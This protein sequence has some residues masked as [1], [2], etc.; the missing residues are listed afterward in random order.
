VEPTEEVAEAA[1]EDMVDVDVDMLDEEQVLEEA[2]VEGEAEEVEVIGAMETGS[3]MPCARRSENWY[4][5][6]WLCC[7]L[8]P[9][10][11][12]CSGR[13]ACCYR[14]GRERVQES[15]RE[16]KRVQ[17]SSRERVQEFKSS[18]ER[19]ERRACSSRAVSDDR[20]SVCIWA[21]LRSLLSAL[22]LSVGD[23][24]SR[25]THVLVHLPLGNGEEAPRA[26]L[27]Q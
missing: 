17:E 24:K 9:F 4:A 19:R 5:I 8:L 20:E 12:V 22:S 21:S 6:S 7:M 26:R 23:R 25:S 14:V 16:F 3:C 18:R 10:V 1:E 11:L 2:A 13:A 27:T 15:S